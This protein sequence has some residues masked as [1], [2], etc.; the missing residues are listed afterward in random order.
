MT[1]T[2]AAIRDEQIALIQALT[3]TSLAAT[4]LRV[5]LGELN[6]REWAAAHPEASLRRFAIQD[7]WDYD[8]PEVHG[9]DMV[10]D[11]ARVEV[12]VAYPK[13]P[14]LYGSDNARD[15]RDIIREDASL[16]DYTIGAWGTGNYSDA[17]A[18]RE[19]LELEDA[20]AV[21]LAVSTF[22]V[23]Y[24]RATTGAGFVATQNSSEQSFQYTT[25][26]SADSYAVT[27]PKAMRDTSYVVEAT[28]STLGSGGAFA[29]LMA[30]NSGRTTTAFTLACSGA[31]ATG[32]VI[33][34]IVRD[35]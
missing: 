25:A 11:P 12:I 9:G 26:S 5:S 13:S 30:S 35:R 16:I 32:T 20:G 8:I 34:I 15:M 31:L 7:I 1:T 3:P 14:A 28:I 23:F 2:L 17:S 22:R 29:Q 21:V 24:Y 6:F 10:F 27:I 19:S 4:K 18:V 33:D